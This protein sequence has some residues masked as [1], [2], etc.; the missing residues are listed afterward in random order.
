MTGWTDRL[1]DWLAG[2]DGGDEG[3]GDGDGDACVEGDGFGD[4]VNDN[5]NGGVSVDGGEMKWLQWW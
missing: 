5:G 1:T 2:G 4:A 3:Q